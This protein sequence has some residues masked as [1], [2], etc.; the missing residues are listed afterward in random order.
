MARPGPGRRPR[1]WRRSSTR[2]R[3]AREARTRFRG[4]AVP[5]RSGP[6]WRR[7]IAHSGPVERPDR[8]S[9]GPV[10]PHGPE[11]R[12]GEA[13]R[14]RS[15]ASPPRR[16]VSPRADRPRSQAAPDCPP[17]PGTR[18]RSRPSPRT[19]HA[20][21]PGRCGHSRG[22][23][24]NGKGRPCSPRLPA[25]ESEVREVTGSAAESPRGHWSRPLWGHP[26]PRHVSPPSDAPSCRCSARRARKAGSPTP[27]R[28]ARRPRTKRCRRPVPRRLAR[29]AP[30]RGVMTRSGR[31]ALR[32]R[33]RARPVPRT[34]CRGDREE[35]RTA[36][37]TGVARGGQP[38]GSRWYLWFRPAGLAGET[39]QRC[40]RW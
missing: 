26:D 39:S 17:G 36:N 19:R 32:W 30:R 22:R 37:L 24:V 15:V 12:S 20:P 4:K 21:R 23:R 25:T 5:Q 40:E 7:S 13:R 27:G 16:P 9:A 35:G 2:A 14:P 1:A 31:R 8:E 38:S 11:M 10:E 3:R 34:R 29:R 33:R 6:K 28:E 18:R